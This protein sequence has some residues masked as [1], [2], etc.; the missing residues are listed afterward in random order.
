MAGSCLRIVLRMTRWATFDCYGT[1]IDWN[2]GIRAELARLWPDQDADELLRRY[3]ELEPEVE[4]AEPG[5]SY[6]EVMQRVL[7]RLGKVPLGEDDA[8]GRSLPGW[9]TFPEVREA[10]ERAR[11]HGWRLAILSNTDRDFIEASKETIGVPFDETVVASEIGSYKP[12]RKHW[13]EFSARTGADPARHVHVAQSMFHDIVVANEL[14]LPSVW[15]N[16]LGERHDTAPTR[17]LPD[18]VALP[19]VLDELVA[20]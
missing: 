7:A 17:E 20:P 6:R 16:R 3:H 13:E 15:I 5:L 9:R 8:L 12:A 19:E 10:L 2:G 4:H 14:G 1:L 11:D 18:L